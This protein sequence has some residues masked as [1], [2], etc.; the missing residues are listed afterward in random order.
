LRHSR[1]QIPRTRRAPDPFFKL[2][3]GSD[4]HAI[5]RPGLLAI[6]RYSGV[7]STKVPTTRPAPKMDRIHEMAGLLGGFSSRSFNR[8]SALSWEIHRAPKVA[9]MISSF[10]PDDLARALMRN[11]HC[12]LRRED[13]GSRRSYNIGGLVPPMFSI[14]VFR[15]LKATF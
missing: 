14:Q 4:C 1:R 10:W 11:L 12:R 13:H 5:W 6:E 2:V 15:M 9:P 7:L 8:W 3:T